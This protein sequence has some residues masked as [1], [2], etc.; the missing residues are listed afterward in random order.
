MQKSLD[1]IYKTLEDTIKAM[2]NVPEMMGGFSTALGQFSQQQ[3]DAFTAFTEAANMLRE[4]EEQFMEAQQYYEE[5]K[6]KALSSADVSKQ[7]DIET[8]STLIY[9][10]NFSMPA[11][12]IADKDAA[13]GCIYCVYRGGQYAAGV[14]RAVHGSPAVL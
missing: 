2:D 9:A 5:A 14:R 10:Q 12:Y 1:I 13:A 3:L 8:L 11:G 7:L 6:Q 4:Y